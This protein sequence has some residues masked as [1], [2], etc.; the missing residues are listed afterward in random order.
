MKRIGNILIPVALLALTAC[1]TVKIQGNSNCT[2][3]TTQTAPK[4]VSVPTNA[5][6]PVGTI[7]GIK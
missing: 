5:T 1:T 7:P 2:I 3:T 4:N 6:V